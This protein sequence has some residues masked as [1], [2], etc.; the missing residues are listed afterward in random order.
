MLKH[1]YFDNNATT[2]MDSDAVKYMT[3]WLS[4][5]SNPSGSTFLSQ[6]GKTGIERTS[7]VVRSICKLTDHHIIYTS[8][9]SESNCTILH[10]VVNA[11]YKKTDKRPHIVAT[12]VEHKA[13]LMCLETLK[14]DYTLVP[15][16]K[17][18]EADLIAFTEAVKRPNT[19][20]STVMYANNETGVINDIATFA[21]VSH[22]ANVPFHTDAV[23]MFGKI[24][25]NIPALGIDALSMSF[26]KL[27]GPQGLGMLILNKRF[28]DGFA[29]QAIICGTQQ[30]GLRGGTENTP[31]IIGAGVALRKNFQDR[32]EKNKHLNRLKSALIQSLTQTYR[33]INYKNYPKT[34][35]GVFICVL[36]ENT[37]P[38]T[39]LLSYVDANR[40]FC[41]VKFKKYMEAHKIIISIGSACN[42]NSANAS[43]VIVAMD[44][45]PEVRRGVMR[46]S[47]GDTNTLDEVEKFVKVFKSGVNSC[48]LS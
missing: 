34:P 20:L 44:A 5:C 42:T 3:E 27:R 30:H 46:I 40:E 38:N 25:I 24:P 1:I 16:S 6:A 4:A 47:F 11:W 45:P 26:H 41:N 29:L 14:C 8:G 35:Q 17:T 19:I 28:V 9:A 2:Q 21:E 23:Q 31:A 37:L 33:V 12:V 39:V 32:G 18:G 10:M 7:A 13:T 22:E 43:H 48:Y 15:V 36:G